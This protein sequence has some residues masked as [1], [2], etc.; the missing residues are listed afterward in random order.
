MNGY[1]F[2]KQ[3]KKINPKVKVILMSSSNSRKRILKL[4]PRSGGRRFHTKAI[5]TKNIKKYTEEEQYSL[6]IRT[7]SCAYQRDSQFI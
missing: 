6:A 4:V 7:A 1:Q 3:V 2:I 5:F